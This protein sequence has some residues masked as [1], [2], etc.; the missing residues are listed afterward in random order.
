MPWKSAFLNTLDPFTR[1]YMETALWS[2]NDESDPD[3]GGDPMDDN[4]DITDIDKA[5][6][7][8][9]IADCKRF[10]EENEKAIADCEDQV[11]TQTGDIFA[12]AGHDFW[13]TRNGHGAGFW[14]GDW[15]EPHA[16]TLDKAS[17]AFGEVHLYIGDDGAIHQTKG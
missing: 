5:S 13:L 2:S 3:T 14:D 1:Q 10:Q 16:T 17:K 4:Y 11:S 12:R 8:E 9:M 15:P 7:D 6:A